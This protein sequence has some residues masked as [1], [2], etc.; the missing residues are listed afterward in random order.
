MNINQAA[1][2]H[3]YLSRSFEKDS[4]FTVVIPA[5]NEENRIKPV[6]QEICAYISS[7][8]LPWDVIVSID[9]ND[10][11]EA[12]V[13]GMSYEYPFL[14]YTK[15]DGRGGKGAAIKRA[16]N[17]AS[18]EFVMLMDA[19]GAISFKEMVKYVSYLG[20]YDLVN[21]NRYRNKENKIPRLRRFVSRG[22]NLYISLLF[23]LDVEDTQCGYKMMETDMAKKLFQKLTITNGFFYSPLFVYLKKMHMKTIEVSVMYNHGD[24]SK[25]NVASMV[26]GG[27]VSALAFRLRNSPL[28]KYVPRKLVDLYYR[29]FRWI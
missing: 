18:G 15:G 23:G 24:G 3:P 25:F 14:S 9:G 22:Y 27:F 20:E 10:G 13:R 7:N 8:N 5:Y 28:W 11:T 17:I 26:L 1:L 4:T 29:K 2:S 6:L 16:I 21:F 19:D 12:L